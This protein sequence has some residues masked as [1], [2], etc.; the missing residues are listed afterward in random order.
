MSKKFSGKLTN[1]PIWAAQVTMY[2]FSD[3][4][5]VY[6][7]R[8]TIHDDTLTGK[9]ALEIRAATVVVKIKI[10]H[11]YNGRFSKQAFR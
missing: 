4:T 10:Y 6:L 9:A 11:E 3:L 2:H 5:Y 7:T 8:S 1:A